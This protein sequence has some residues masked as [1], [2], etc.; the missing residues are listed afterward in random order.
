[1]FPLWDDRPTKTKPFVCILLIVVN[2]AVFLHEIQLDQQLRN[3]FI[4]RFGLVPDRLHFSALVTM[5]FL[6]GGWMHIIGNMV[7]LW[8]FGKSLE[9]AM[10]HGKFLVFYLLTGVAA[11]LTQ[12][13]FNPGSQVPMVGASG[14]IAGVMGGYLLKFPKARIYSLVFIFIFI[15]RVEIPALFFLPYWF[16]SQ[17]VSGYGTVAYSNLSE[18]GIAYFA[19]IGGFVAGMVLVIVLGTRARTNR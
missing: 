17:V 5:Q 15:A 10:G 1:M 14:A 11:A 3:E 8:A 18:G 12:V 13:F 9:D 19:H 6:H 7:F 2:I 16:L 4:M